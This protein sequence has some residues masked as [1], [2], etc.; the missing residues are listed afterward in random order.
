[1]NKYWL[2][3]KL[4]VQE[5]FEYRF[6]FLMHT[7]KYVMSI[8]LM[9]LIWSAVA[10][11]SSNQLFTPSET[12]SYFFFGAIIYSLSN[13]HTYYIE[14]DIRYGSLSKYL[15]KPLSAWA[16]Y[17]TLQATKATLETVLKFAVMTPLLLILNF[18]LTFSLSSM[19][20]FTAFL[21]F[22]FIFSMI[23]LSLISIG[24][25]WIQDVW[26]VRWAL[27]ILFRFLSG[28]LVPVAYFPEMAQKLLYWLP[29]QH[30]AYTP[31]R[32]IQG[33]LPIPIALQSLVILLC[34]TAVMYALYN[35]VWK[36]GLLQ[37][38]S[39]GA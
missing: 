29:F 4:S 24:A 35:Q 20:I 28:I 5:E 23:T 34:W 7:A 19:V 26:A 13:F 8:L 11:E 21:P 36:A 1:M 25:F 16:Y 6:D 31:I 27:T 9:A 15:L 39:A 3:A 37:Y 32:L 12:V 33:Q 30:L 22:I 14:E 38:E 2:I 10:R 18:G 17:T